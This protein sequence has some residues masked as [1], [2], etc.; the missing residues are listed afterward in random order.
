MWTGKDNGTDIDR[1]QALAYCRDLSLGG[2][3]WRLPTIDE[4][5]GI[6]D[7]DAAA[8]GRGGQN[9]EELFLFHIKGNLFLTGSEWSRDALAG[10]DGRP[11][12]YSWYFNFTDGSRMAD[13]DSQTYNKHALCVRAAD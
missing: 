11:S 7:L 2:Y 12:G 4:L 8:P 10:D 13:P 1:D 6:Y 5:E 3:H 9:D